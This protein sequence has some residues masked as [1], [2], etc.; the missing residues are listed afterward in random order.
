M[1]GTTPL[2]KLK[3]ADKVKDKHVMDY[4]EFTNSLPAES[5]SEWTNMIKLWEA[6]P[7]NTNPFVSTTKSKWSWILYIIVLM[8]GKQSR[9]TVYT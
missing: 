8:A 5:I 2:C 9:S 1:K 3:S 7:S 6:D 4:L